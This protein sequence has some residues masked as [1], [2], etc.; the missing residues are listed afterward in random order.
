MII[1]VTN[2]DGILADGLWALVVELKKIGPVVVVAPAEER[3]GVGT[4]VTLRQP[5]RVQSVTP[6]IPEVEAYSVDGTPADSVILALGKLA[7]NRIDLVV[8]GINNGPNLGED[9]F[10]SGTVGAA[11]Q[12]YLH[13]LPALAVSM[14]AVNSPY[15]E[16]VAKLAACWPR[17]L[18]SMPC[19]GI[20]FS[21]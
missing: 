13:G 6:L 20:L 9:V 8:S 7:T 12:G 4:A 1:L 17:R 3:S 21:T 16:G 5:L 18:T 19:P 10:I 15:L 11:L 14:D 2:D